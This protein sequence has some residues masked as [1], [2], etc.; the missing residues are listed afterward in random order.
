[1]SQLDEGTED[2]VKVFSKVISFQ[3]GNNF[4]L[5]SLKKIVLSWIQ[6]KSCRGNQL[7]FPQ[8]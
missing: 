1:M 4:C 2:D 3:Q 8:V 7:I 5:S 6:M